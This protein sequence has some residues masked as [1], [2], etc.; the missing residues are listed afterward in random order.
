MDYVSKI[1]YS[2]KYDN[3]CLLHAAKQ[4]NIGPRVHCER[5]Y[6]MLYRFVHFFVLFWFIFESQLHETVG[7]IIVSKDVDVHSFISVVLITLVPHKDM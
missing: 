2:L 7:I 6:E 5:Q 1:I 4:N 3:A